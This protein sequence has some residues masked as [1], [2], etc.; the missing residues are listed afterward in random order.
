[1]VSRVD[2]SSALRSYTA[3]QIE[4]GF[5]VQKCGILN[6]QARWRRPTL[7]LKHILPH[8]D[9]SVGADKS[10]DFS[11][12]LRALCCEND[13]A[14]LGDKDIVFDTNANSGPFGVNLYVVS[15]CAK[16]QSGLDC[17][18]HAGCEYAFRHIISL[19]PSPYIVYIKAK[20][21]PGSMH[22]IF[23]IGSIEILTQR[24]FK[25]AI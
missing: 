15:P 4:V 19:S 25:R 18:N 23:S 11:D 17:E 20:E 10:L 5:F 7:R 3:E 14:I 1:M 2:I 9:P 8:F 6:T 24:F 22:E 13:R 12:L 21:M 16:V